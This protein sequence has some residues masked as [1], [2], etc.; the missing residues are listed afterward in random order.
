MISTLFKDQH[1]YENTLLVLKRYETG[2]Y[3]LLVSRGLVI[4]DLGFMTFQ[5]MEVEV[6][7]LRVY[8]GLIVLK[9]VWGP[10]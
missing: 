10:K 9:S 3:I 4:S 1:N 2:V 8:L 7:R 6:F 5:A